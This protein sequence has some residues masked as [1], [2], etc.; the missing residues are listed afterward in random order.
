MKDSQNITIID[1]QYKSWVQQLVLRY[2]QSQIKAAVKVNQ[3]A[4]IFYWSLGRDIVNL[5]AESKWGSKL[6]KNLSE[7]LK[8][9]LPDVGCFS[10][11]NLLYM[12]N[13]YLL[14]QPITPQVE[15]QLVE[16]RQITPQVG[17]QLVANIFSIP[18]GHHKLLIDKYKK[19]PE[20]ALFFVRKTIENGWSRAML[21]NFIDTDLY[22]RDSKAQKN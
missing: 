1:P 12:K 17:E 22:E 7:D 6:L 20:K 19:H 11:T 10:E 18:W 5:Q 14:Y 13:F 15:E 2:R 21:L 8:K 4:L 3:E 16:S 9:A